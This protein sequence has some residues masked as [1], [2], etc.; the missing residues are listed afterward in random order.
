[1]SN[2]TFEVYKKHSEVLNTLTNLQLA[3]GKLQN[4]KNNNAYWCSKGRPT[5]DGYFDLEKEYEE[6]IT[7]NANTYMRELEMLKA[8]MIVNY[9]KLKK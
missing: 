1:M 2:P 9:P 8:Q 3:E 6:A 7:A 4:H 5:P